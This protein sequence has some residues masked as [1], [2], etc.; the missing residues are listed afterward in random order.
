MF[1]SPFYGFYL[2]WLN[3]LQ[4][5][6]TTTSPATLYNLPPP[7][8]KEKLYL[9][10]KIDDTLNTSF[11]NLKNGIVKII[12]FLL[13]PVKCCQF[14]AKDLLISIRNVA[15]RVEIEKSRFQEVLFDEHACKLIVL[16]ER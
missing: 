1:S 13:N 2:T 9:T 14:K 8:W 7:F 6:Q 5:L 12:F 16:N 3:P 15:Y 4:I 10:F 11:V